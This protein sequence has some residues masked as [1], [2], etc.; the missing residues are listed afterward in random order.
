MH[1]TYEFYNPFAHIPNRLEWARIHSPTHGSFD[2]F[3][4]IHDGT[5]R[6]VTVYVAS[7]AGERF[8]HDRYPESSCIRVPP[9]ALSLTSTQAGLTV[10]GRLEAAEG[11]VRSAAMKFVADNDT[12]PKATPYGGAEQPVW[13]SRYTCNGVDLELPARVWGTVAYSDGTEE[14][15]GADSVVTLGSYGHIVEL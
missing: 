15:A 10:E 5:H 2:S 1:G 6:P 11:P 4:V 7:G 13:G 12:L 9:E 3:I 14:L 8:L